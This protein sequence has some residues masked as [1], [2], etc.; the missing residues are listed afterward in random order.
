MDIWVRMG[1]LRFGMMGR[2]PSGLEASR[3]LLAGDLYQRLRVVYNHRIRDEIGRDGKSSLNLGLS[4][5]IVH[6]S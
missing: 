1:I 2:L 5:G 6:E 4:S 3:L